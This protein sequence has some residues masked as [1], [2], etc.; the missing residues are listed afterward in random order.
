MRAAHAYLLE[1]N[2][3]AAQGFLTQVEIA[4]VRRVELI[5]IEKVKIRCAVAL[6]VLAMAT[7][8]L[9]R[10]ENAHV[11]GEGVQTCETWT[12]MKSEPTLMPNPLQAWV[13]GFASAFNFVVFANG[14]VMHGNDSGGM[15]LWLDNYCAANPTKPIYAAAVEFL[16]V[17]DP[18]HPPAQK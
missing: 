17:N 5:R 2:P 10:P 6:A 3:P 18:D 9:A 14:D 7:S 8:A 12:K 4:D 13:R 15:I 1:E 11:L 16:R